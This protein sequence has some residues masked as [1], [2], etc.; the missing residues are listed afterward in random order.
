VAQDDIVRTVAEEHRAG[1]LPSGARLAP[2]RVLEHQ[3]GISKNTV[4]AAYDEL[5]A[6]GVLVSKE[7]D[8]VFVAEAA[9]SF[10]SHERLMA[11]ALRLRDLGL[12]SP[13]SRSPE[14]IPLDMV[15]VDPALMPKERVAECFRS[16]LNIPGLHDLYDAQGHPPLREAISRRLVAR[17]MDVTADDIVITTGSQQALDAVCRVLLRRKIA[18]E[19]PVYH[20]GKVL[21]QSLDAELTGLRL[22][23][24]GPLPVDEW[25]AVLKATRPELFY[26]VTSFHNPTGRSYSTHELFQILE[27]SRELDFGLLEDDWGSDMLSHT[28]YRPTLRALGGPEVLYVNSFTKKLLPSLRL[29]FVAGNSRTVPALVAAKRVGTLANPTLIEAALTEFLERGYFDTHLQTMQAELDQRYQFCL[30]TLNEVMPEGVRWTTPGG[31]V[32]VWLELPP[33]VDLARLKEALFR[34][35]VVIEPKPQAFQGKPHLHGFPIGYAYLSSERLAIALNV[36]AEEIV[37]A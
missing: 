32:L 34:R 5:C 1:R 27:L 37:R 7:R 4:Q 10:A 14:C 23:P 13:R 16:V 26:T 12:S 22:D 18:I 6:R 20:H 3:L 29:G 17:G 8:G 24:F 28:E 25:R 30:T 36:L 33:S 2:V 11:P 19:D 15:F 35:K 9:T 21:F 31:G